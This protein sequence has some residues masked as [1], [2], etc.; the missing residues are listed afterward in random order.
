MWWLLI[1]LVLLV[2]ALIFLWLDAKS[3]G[4]SARREPGPVSVGAGGQG[5]TSED[6][7]DE[8]APSATA[9]APG[10]EQSQQS[11]QSE[12]SENAETTEPAVAS[13]PAESESPE[14]SP[15]P[16]PI[17]VGATEETERRGSEATADD[18]AVAEE[19][20]SA[21]DGGETAAD[22]PQV[23]DSAA[24]S[25]DSS[26]L[27]AAAAVAGAGAAGAAGA[28][29]APKLS[30][31]VRRFLPSRKPDRSPAGPPQDVEPA[32][33]LAGSP[34]VQWLETREFAPTPTPAPDFRHGD[35]S[36]GLPA[37]GT[38]SHGVF[39][40][41]HAIMGVAGGRAVLALQ[42]ETASDVVLDLSRPDVD[43]EPGLHDAGEMAALEAR[44]SDYGRLELVDR[45]RLSDAVQGLP[46]DVRRIWAEDE[47]L[48]ATV[49][50]ADNPATWDDTVMALYSAAD[51]LAPLPPV[52][53]RAHPLPTEMDPGAPGALD[54]PEADPSAGVPGPAGRRMP[55]SAAATAPAAAVAPTVAGSGRGPDS[56]DVPGEGDAGIGDDTAAASTLRRAGHLRLVPEKREGVRDLVDEPVV[57]DRGE[58]EEEASA[59]D[60]ATGADENAESAALAE[61][62]EPAAPT[63]STE[64]TEPDPFDEIMEPAGPVPSR[65]DVAADHLEPRPPLARPTRGAGH[66]Y[67]ED[68]SVPPLASGVTSG[69][70]GLKPLGSENDEDDEDE[71]RSEVE[72]FDAARIDGGSDLDSGSSGR[73][74]GRAEGEVPV[75]ERPDLV[76]TT[77]R[78]GRRRHRRAEDDDESDEAG[79]SGESGEADQSTE[80][81]G[82]EPDVERT[83]RIQIPPG[84]DE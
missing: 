81:P 45:D 54:G 35:F 28:A 27:P 75:W 34:V 69:G 19:G 32:D 3:R 46:A 38:V 49:D 39:R 72:R 7:D 15:R 82:V 6:D 76:G 33:P 47:W 52:G 56:G 84:V 65:G 74:G 36:G 63:E 48:A 58:T 41:R 70:S 8:A 59:A 51:V 13:A 18:E 61:L 77:P 4:S 17:E 29:A 11:E 44:T 37:L 79:E 9:T 1:A 40:G 57:A 62:A 24:D 30:D 10:A 67:P 68:A 50:G 64:S 20:D 5:S 53:G 26:G 23:G 60:A 66:T 43:A 80:R 55:P 12:H 22:A 42:R 21:A 2:A 71:I 25:D 31:R 83:M 78:P 73:H 14:P 16:A